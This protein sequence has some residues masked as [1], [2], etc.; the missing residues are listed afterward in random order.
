MVKPMDCGV[1]VSKFKLQYLYYF[2][3]NSFEK[4]YEL[5]Y[6]LIYGLNSTTFVLLEA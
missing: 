1:V 2:P 6:P 4:A 5:A 3:T